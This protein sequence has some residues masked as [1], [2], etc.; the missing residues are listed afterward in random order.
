M[1][2][3]LILFYIV[4]IGL[5]LAFVVLTKSKRKYRY[6]LFAIYLAVVVVV[7]VPVLK[8]MYIF[9]GIENAFPDDCDQAVVL[10]EGSMNSIVGVGVYGRLNNILFGVSPDVY[11]LST[12]AVC[13]YRDG[14]FLEAEIVLDELLASP[15]IKTS[16]NIDVTYYENLRNK[17][18]G[19]SGSSGSSGSE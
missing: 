17:L 5:P 7:S 14:A 6:I 2:I 8:F 15:N 4:V 12:I 3:G 13:K 16:R 1:S 19:S 18:R 10:S 9:D 11:F